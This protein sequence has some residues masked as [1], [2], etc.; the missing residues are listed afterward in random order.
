ML[1]DDKDCLVICDWEQEGTLQHEPF[2]TMILQV[3][4]DMYLGGTTVCWNGLCIAEAILAMSLLHATPAEHVYPEHT[5]SHY[6]L[7]SGT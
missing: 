6:I 3:L 5:V 2:S 4:T 7:R 1:A